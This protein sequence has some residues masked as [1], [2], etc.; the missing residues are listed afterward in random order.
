[1][2]ASDGDRDHDLAASALLSVLLLAHPGLRST[3]EL[4]RELAEEPA[5]FA[6][7]DRVDDAIRDLVSTGLAHRHGAFVFATRAAVRF[8]EL[9]S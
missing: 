6:E 4:V 2:G 8:D 1:M 7:R 3:E 9:R 5:D